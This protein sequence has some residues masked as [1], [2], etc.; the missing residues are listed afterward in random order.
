MRRA[1][2]GA[3]AN[4]FMK[5]ALV[6]G[7][8]CSL[9]L[10]YPALLCWQMHWEVRHTYM[11][12]RQ[13]TFDGRAYMLY[14]RFPKWILLSLVTLGIYGIFVLPLNLQRWKTEHTHVLGV[15]GCSSKF[16]GTV[17]GLWWCSVSNFL[18]TVITLGIG[19]CWTRCRKRRWY[20]EHTVIDDGNVIFDGRAGQYFGKYIVWTLL[21]VVTV[22]VYSVWLLVKTKQWTAYHTGFARAE[23]LPVPEAQALSVV[24]EEEVRRRLK[25]ER[26]KEGGGM[27]VAGALCL[28][29]FLCFFLAVIVA[30]CTVDF[31]ATG[32]DMQNLSRFIRQQFSYGLPLWKAFQNA[33]QMTIQP[34][35]WME[36][37]S[38][39]MFDAMLGAGIVSFIGFGPGVA[40]AVLN[41]RKKTHSLRKTGGWGMA[42]NGAVVT[43]NLLFAFLLPILLYPSSNLGLP[44]GF[45]GALTPP[46]LISVVGAA[47][48][49]GLIAASFGMRTCRDKRGKGGCIAAIVI[50]ALIVAVLIG[51][52]IFSYVTATPY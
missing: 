30:L 46:I 18:L 41:R 8:L 45:D 9:G 43:F 4:F 11:N 35:P 1:R 16:T 19:W 36:K 23:A 51:V 2:C 42:L 27:T 3:A 25:I 31:A 48:F 33:I 44:S 52:I 20:A 28:A 10:A 13:L 14:G 50:C 21:T 38:I 39:S 7:T 29:G 5:L 6:L 32:E 26:K 22:G 12:G 34:S 17:M 40:G 47:A 24:R 49:S 15:T 37:G